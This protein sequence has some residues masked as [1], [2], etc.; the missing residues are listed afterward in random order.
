MKMTRVFIPLVAPLALAISSVVSAGPSGY[1]PPPPPPPEKQEFVVRLG[2]SY[3]S[4]RDDKVTFVDETFEFFDAF[5]STVDPDN[6]WGWYF[7][8]EWKPVHHWGFELSYT[9][10]D[11]HSGGNADGYLSLFFEGERFGDIA[12]FEPQISTASVKFYPL[13]P[14][15]LIQPYVGGGISY[16]DFGSE[17]FR[18]ATRAE[19]DELGLR[20]RANL[21]YSW[22]YT[23][24]LGMDFNFGHDSAWLVN[25]A[26]V[27]SRATSDIGF[28]IF[29]AETPPPDVEPFLESYSGDYI[30][31]PWMF[32]LSV[33]YRFSF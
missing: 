23:W 28:Q 15:C 26:A 24:Q 8:A 25:A 18:G 22:G 16:T 32:N 13:D 1:A 10:G 12:R 5:R 9:D 27:Y 7:S 11:T 19:L 14:S 30:F 6:E 21:G 20:G 29:D 4:P 31:D 3:I 33:G 2:A 17:N